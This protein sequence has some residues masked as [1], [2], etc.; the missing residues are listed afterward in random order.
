MIAICIR[1]SLHANNIHQEC[2]ILC[3]LKRII[4]W[5]PA[6]GTYTCQQPAKETYTCQRP[7]EETYTCQQPAEGTYTCQLLHR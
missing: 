1:S 2:F 5:Q 3:V 7:A 6:E 4:K